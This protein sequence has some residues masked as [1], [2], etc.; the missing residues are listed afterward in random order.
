MAPTVNALTVFVF[1]IVGHTTVMLDNN[2][3]LALEDAVTVAIDKVLETASANLLKTIDL[4][5]VRRYITDSYYVIVTMRDD[6]M[7]GY[8]MGWGKSVV[9]NG[10]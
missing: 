9:S 7:Q 6:V 1:D 3:D 4:Q 10:V 5:T 2:P 8:P